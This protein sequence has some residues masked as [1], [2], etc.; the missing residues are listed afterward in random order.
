MSCCRSFTSTMPYWRGERLGFVQQAIESGAG[1][2]VVAAL[3][4][5]PEE[6]FLFKPRYSAF[7]QTPLGP[8][9]EELAIERVILIGAATEGC[10][11][12]TAIDARELKLKATIL[13]T[14]CATANSDLEH[15]A[16]AYATDVGGVRL[17][18]TL[19]EARSDS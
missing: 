8:V 14:S 16:L 5:E 3:R 6:R 13:K 2:D 12:Q 4:P 17:G 19:E 7:D 9:L 1:G 15:V 10:V 11:V 18:S